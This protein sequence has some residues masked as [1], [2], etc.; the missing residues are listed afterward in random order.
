MSIL[1]RINSP[2][3]LRSLES[4]ETEDLCREIRDFLVETGHIE[5]VQVVEEAV[6]QVRG[7]A[8]QSA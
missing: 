4:N 6:A 5:V 2:T 7:T 8:T 1:E 3:D